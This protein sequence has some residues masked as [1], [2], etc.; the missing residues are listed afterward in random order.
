MQLQ[1]TRRTIL[2]N[3]AYLFSG[4]AIT[5]AITAVTT[6][7]IA[8]QLGPEIYGQ[9]AASLVFVS[10][11]SIIFSL[12]LN[13]WLLH[14]ASRNP[15]EHR[16]LLGSVLAL[17]LLIGIPWLVATYLLAGLMNSSTF[18]REILF[19][20]AIVVLLD[21]I[22]S[23]LLTSFKVLFKNQFTFVLML[24]SD[25]LWMIGTLGLIS[26]DQESAPIFITI[27]IIT[28]VFSLILS[29]RLAW[30]LIH[31]NW[32]T[33]SIKRALKA[34]F[35]YATSEL[36][37]MSSLRID[38]LIV[39]LVLGAQAAGIYAPA[40]GII[41]ALFLPLSSIS[42]VV[43]PILSNRFA[44]NTKHA[45]NLARRSIWLFLI[46]GMGISVA[47]ALGARFVALV[48]GSGYSA[49]QEI[50][51]ILSIIL[52]LHALILAMTNILIATD[53]QGKR[54]IIQTAVV[55]LNIVLDLIVVPRAGIRGAAWVYVI[56]EGVMLI[57]LVAL[58][59]A[60]QSRSKEVM[61]HP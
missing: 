51:Q 15:N 45:W 3:I 57:G 50:V 40:V 20:S 16:T 33:T 23:T 25:L 1:F 22:F 29:G 60:T 9:Y 31:P 58:V 61:V 17:K 46:M 30:S 21:N 11:T 2:G 54:A 36:L 37:I 6:L 14:E 28:L 38:I 47:V 55:I 27:R 5:Q 43:L 34:S 52:L 35:P 7:L 49:S 32:N 18:P 41:N 42:G 8:R 12:G 19:L 4:T 39:A 53:Q 10:F 48:L 56:T 59:I 24:V 26:K 13:T 44:N